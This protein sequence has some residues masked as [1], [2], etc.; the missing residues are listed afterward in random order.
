MECLAGE[1]SKVLNNAIT[2][3]F[4]TRQ[5]VKAKKKMDVLRTKLPGA[6]TRD[7]VNWIRENR[8]SGL[9]N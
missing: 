7:I 3:W 5:R 2:A 9:N 6:S 8:A 4:K 1:R